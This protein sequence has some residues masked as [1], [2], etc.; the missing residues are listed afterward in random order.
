MRNAAAAEWILSLVAAPDRTAS[1]IGD[2]VEEASARGILW[3][4]SSVLRTAC[5]YLWRDLRASPL[6]M[7][8]LA[9]WGLLA[10][11]WFSA[12]FGILASLVIRVQVN[13]YTT[14]PAPWVQPMMQ[15]LMCTGIPFL[16]GWEVARRSAS[17][18]LTAAF[19]VAALFVA[20]YGVSLC[21][22]AMQVRRIGVPWPGMEHPLIAL[23]M[24]C[25]EGLS[26]VAGAILFRRRTLAKRKSIL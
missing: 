14:G 15:V 20:G 21:L 7:V 8:R 11:W 16:V 2:L 22:S 24:C 3:F 4:W 23:A 25:A 10:F 12:A 6:R 9:F 26:V 18:E 17:R 19:G 13:S 5:S 1:T